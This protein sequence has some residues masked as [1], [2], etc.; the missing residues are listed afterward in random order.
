MRKCSRSV[1]TIYVFVPL[2]ILRII[3]LQQAVD[4]N[5]AKIKRPLLINMSTYIFVIKCRAVSKLF[6][7]RACMRDRISKLSPNDL[8][9]AGD[10]NFYI[11]NRSKQTSTGIPDGGKTLTI[12]RYL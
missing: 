10:W 6:L 2:L 12:S 8:L 7:M 9:H 11:M 1:C 5:M 4:L 3:C